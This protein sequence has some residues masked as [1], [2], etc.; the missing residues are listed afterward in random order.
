MLAPSAERDQ[1]EADLRLAQ[2]VPLIAVH[3]YGAQAVEFCA[4]RAKELGDRILPV[5]DTPSGLPLSMV[6]LGK[7]TGVYSDW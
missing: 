4:S 2:E 7:R 6:N 1:L 3:G 5:F